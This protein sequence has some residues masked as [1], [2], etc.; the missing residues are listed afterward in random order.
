MVK[1]D[2]IYFALVKG[3]KMKCSHSRWGFLVML[4]LLFGVAG[5]SSA[6]ALNSEREGYC[7]RDQRAPLYQSASLPLRNIIIPYRFKRGVCKN[8][9]F[10]G[11]CN[12]TT[13]KYAHTADN[14]YSA[15]YKIKQIL[16]QVILLP[17]WQGS[18]TYPPLRAPPIA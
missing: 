6:V 10:N 8:N 4:V 1:L 5:A 7:S 9:K 18:G 16:S 17:D 11:N 14:S 3:L 15:L 13:S 12:R 2:F